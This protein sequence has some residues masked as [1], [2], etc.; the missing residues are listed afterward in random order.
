MTSRVNVRTCTYEHGRHGIPWRL[1]ACANRCTRRSFSPPPR[2][3]TR[4]LSSYAHDWN[5][6]AWWR[7]KNEVTVNKTILTH[8]IAT[9]GSTILVSWY[10]II[11]VCTT[12]VCTWTV[13]ESHLGGNLKYV[14][15]YS[16]DCSCAFS[17]VIELMF[18]KILCLCN[19]HHCFLLSFLF[20]VV[21]LFLSTFCGAPKIAVC[22][23]DHLGPIH[24]IV[25]EF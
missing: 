8:T 4:L 24:I 18:C 20:I 14:V 11:W 23:H 10:H 12:V 7:I 25:W 5:K 21:I 6:S 13:I 22:L 17:H 9:V 16:F 1:S 19:M 15:S 3:G 2:L